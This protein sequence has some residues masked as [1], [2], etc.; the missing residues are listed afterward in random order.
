MTVETLITYLIYVCGAVLI[1]LGIRYF[2]IGIRQRVHHPEQW[3]EYRKLGKIPV[4]LIAFEKRYDDKIRL[5]NLWFQ[6][7]RLDE[8]YI[9]GDFAELGVYK[10]DS[11][12]IINKLDPERML[13]LFDTFKGFSDNDL[14]FETGEAARY[15]WHDFADTDAEMV[16][17]KLGMSDRVVIHEG[18]FPLTTKG[19]EEVRFA[20]VHIDADLYA[21]IKAGLEFFYP[22]LAPGGVIMVHDYSRQWEGLRKAVD[23]FSLTIPE[24]L[25]HVADRFGTVM[26]VKNRHI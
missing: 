5:Y 4:E 25:I 3:T 24:T 12:W 15:S 22:R 17:Q 26:I 6:I 8:E 10:G 18:Y 2:W 19:L 13:H 11:A 9:P 1:W 21:P 20:L 23:D 7:K 14:A 16:M